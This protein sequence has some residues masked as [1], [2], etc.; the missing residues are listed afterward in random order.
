MDGILRCS[1]P[2]TVLPRLSSP[3]WGFSLIQFLYPCFIPSSPPFFQFSDGLLLA[4]LFTRLKH[5]T[6]PGLT[7]PAKSRAAALHNV[8][9]VLKNFLETKVWNSFRSFTIFHSTLLQ[10][11]SVVFLNSAEKIV[12]GNKEEII[13]LITAIRKSH[14]KMFLAFYCSHFLKISRSLFISSVFLPSGM[15]YINSRKAT[16]YCHIFLFYRVHLY[17]IGFEFHSFALVLTCIW[18]F[19]SVLLYRKGG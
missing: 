14:I 6:I 4:Q 13:K 16:L 3:P 19:S 5:K 10:S 7:K 1:T 15:H 8:N 12:E 17:F 2:I 11:I 18:V 9:L